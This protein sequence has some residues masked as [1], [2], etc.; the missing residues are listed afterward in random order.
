MFTENEF[1]ELKSILTKEIKK[2]IVAF[3]NTKGGTIYIGVND[4]GT[5]KGLKNASDDVETL[6]AMIRDGIKS[7]LSIYTSM[8]IKK[9]DDKE[10]IELK[11]MEA[12]NKPY[13]LSDKG[14][15]PNGVFLR[16]GNVSAP[17]TDEVIKKILKEN[18]D[19]FENEISGN[20]NLHFKYA[21][22]IFNK[23]NI[24][25]NESKYKVLGI[26][27]DDKYYTNLG[28]LLSDECPF[29]IKCAIFEGNN[30]ITFKDRKEFTGS[31][32]KQLEDVLEYM[33][34]VNRISAR[35]IDYKR[36]DIPDYPEYAIR[37]TI[38][39]AIIHRNYN[40]SGSILISVFDSKI[41]IVS[42]GGLVSGITINDIISGVSQPRNKNLANI[43]YRLEYV[44][45]YGTG[46]GRMID[47]YNEFNLKPEFLTTENTF[48]VILPNVNY[49]EE[50]LEQDVNTPKE[51]TQKEKIINH[52]NENEKI[53]REIVENILKVSS[54]RA[55]NILLEMLDEKTITK[56]GNGRNVYY[57]LNNK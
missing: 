35:I 39:N 23:N 31:I 56:L 26:M 41:E 50:N 47:I 15:R 6:S 36:V 32:L 44:E 13:Y 27:N 10:I 28:L 12:P 7:D 38:L 51:L 16:H 21:N 37:E 25:F 57:V 29:S 11:I 43:F 33:K 48:K 20:Q 54:T 52:L 14:L 1:T 9:I 18:H 22:E 24:E 45:S 5:I 3:A 19:S 34:L 53:T 2:E 4:D 55:K 30:K 42:L 49:K 17:A 8:D 40:F 46:I